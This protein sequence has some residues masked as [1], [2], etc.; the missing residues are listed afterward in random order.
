MVF[1]FPLLCYDIYANIFPC[2]Y[3]K[4]MFV[5][6]LSFLYGSFHFLLG[7]IT[8]IPCKGNI[9]N[10]SIKPNADGLFFR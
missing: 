7:T 4:S 8:Y 1:M 3:Y 9:T 5:N 2:K 6:S 10:E